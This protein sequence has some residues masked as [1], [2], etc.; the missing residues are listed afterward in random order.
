M[1]RQQRLKAIKAS[2][3]DILPAINGEVF[4]YSC[5]TTLSMALPEP[6][7]YA[8]QRATFGYRATQL[9]LYSIMGYEKF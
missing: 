1:N 6:V 8:R 3:P 9:L 7:L 5:I 4:F 2:R